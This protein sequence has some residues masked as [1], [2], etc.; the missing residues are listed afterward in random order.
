MRR[1]KRKRSKKRWRRRRRKKKRSKKRWR[2]RK[3]RWGRSLCKAL[4]QLFLVLR[5]PHM[6]YEFLAMY[7]LLFNHDEVTDI[8]E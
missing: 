5:L 2:G 8:D 7:L 4:Q 6:G 3:K 1:R